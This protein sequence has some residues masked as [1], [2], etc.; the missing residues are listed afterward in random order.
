M[1]LLVATAGRTAV[2]RWSFLRQPPVVGVGGRVRETRRTLV[3]DCWPLSSRTR[4]SVSSGI[5]SQQCCPLEENVLTWEPH[6]L[7]EYWFC[8]ASCCG[9][10]GFMVVW[11]VKE[12]THKVSI[13]H[14][15]HS[16]EPLGSSRARQARLDDSRPSASV[17]L[18]NE[19]RR[20]LV[21]D[22]EQRRE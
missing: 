15:P 14:L 21:D 11:Q 8:L 18:Q 6:D 3:D 17:S 9:A 10:A 12:Q 7:R 20:T 1:A 4:P 16:R 2:G 13:Q 19:T 5:L 22:F